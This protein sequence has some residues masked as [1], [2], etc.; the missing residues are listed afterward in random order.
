MK[1]LLILFIVSIALAATA[2]AQ[3]KIPVGSKLFIP[4]ME[5]ELNGFITTEVLKQKLP[6]KVVVDDKDADYVLVGSSVHVDDKWYN[7][8]F[9]GVKDKNE[10]NVQLLEVK[11]KAI[12]W[13]GEAG[14]RSLW[15]GGLKRGGERKVAE[16]IVKEMHKELFGK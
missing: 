3:A 10:A 11:T 6:L 16:R 1:H 15:F 4:H 7:A 5:G 8:V 12:V 14:D 2:V 13:A 9:G